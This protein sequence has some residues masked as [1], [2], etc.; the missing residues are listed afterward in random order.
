MKP[1][2]AYEQL[3]KPE[4]PPAPQQLGR[5]A[6]KCSRCAVLAAALFTL[7]SCLLF[8]HLFNTR[9]GS[10]AP[11]HG[12]GDTGGT[13][14]DPCRLRALLGVIDAARDFVH[15]A[16]MSYLPT[17]EFSH[18]R[19][20]WPLIDDHLRKAVYERRVR[21]RLL[22]GCW[23]HSKA[24]MFPF[25]KSLAAV[26]DNETRYSVQVRLFMVPTSAAQAKIPYARVNHNKY[27]VTEE[28]AYIGTSNWSGAYF[29][30]TAG[31][32]LVVNET[33]GTGP[34]AVRAQLQAVFERD[35]SSPYSA[36]VADVQRWQ[37]LCGPR[38][39]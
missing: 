23:R 19:R 8:I 5:L 27:M 37:R 9:P 20:F 36:D 2:V 18:P 14:S 38:S 29:T 22:V 32:A 13:C 1:Y 26:A 16:V 10:A 3:E 33:G 34:A 35:W 12:A 28:V 15:V 30:R 4:E 11:G 39:A 17:M 7:L 6:Q 24:D 31:S 25:L 21:V